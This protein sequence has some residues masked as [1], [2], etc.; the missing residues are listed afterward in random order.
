MTSANLDIQ[1]LRKGTM[2]RVLETICVKFD[3]NRPNHLGCRAV[4]D[5]QKD[6]QTHRQI[7]RQPRPSSVSLK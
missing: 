3:Q 7:H 6:R 2:A 4:T 5:R 1:N